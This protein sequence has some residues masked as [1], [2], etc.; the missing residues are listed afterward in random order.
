MKLHH[1]GVVV[2]KIGRDGQR[3]AE[4]FGLDAVSEVIHDPIQRVNVQFWGAGADVSVEFI[5]PAAPDSP[6]GQFLEKGGGLAHVC[7]EVPDLDTALREAESRGAIPVQPPSPAPAFDGR[8][9]AFL[10]YRGMGLVEF[11]EA[12]KP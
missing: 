6:V 5:E 3:L 11:V 4:S 9:I 2:K 10:Y 8:R 1:V 12:A 7:F